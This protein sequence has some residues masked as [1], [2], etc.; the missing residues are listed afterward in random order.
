[1]ALGWSKLSYSLRTVTIQIVAK[2]S[3]E[4]APRRRLL[5]AQTSS[6]R[7]SHLTRAPTPNQASGLAVASAFRRG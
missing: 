4:S 3:S 6:P 7:I 5:L 1:M 2:R